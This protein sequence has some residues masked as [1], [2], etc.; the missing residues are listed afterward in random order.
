MHDVAKPEIASVKPTRKIVI[1]AA[2]AVVGLFLILAGI[3]ALQIVK[4]VSSKPPMPVETVTSAQEKEEDWAPVLSSVGSVSAVQG[5]IVSVELGGT[6]SEVGFE[7]G[8]VAKKGDVLL[9]LD[10]S[11]EQAQLRTA[12]ADLELARADLER[13]RGL[14]ALNPNVDPLTR[15]VQVQATLENP[16][17]VLRPG[18]FA[19]VDVVLPE[20]H[21]ALVI[22]GSAISYAPYG[23]SVFV[24]EKKKDPK[25]GKESQTIRQ[26]FVRVGEA[27]GDFVSI[28][29]G[30][31]AGETVVGTGV[32]KLR[33]GMAVTIN[34]DL[35]PKPQ[36]NPTP[37]DS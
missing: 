25:S 21:K 1:K 27:R 16:D 22:P 17:H 14:T 8:G 7:S 34:N 32:F 35:A 2:L 18:M 11:S 23:D 12:E 5:A 36:V 13:S 15:N 28:N 30:L 26:Q 6:V 24:I 31:E 3:K 20:K 29:N 10:T 4:M 37:V 19:K 9:R 33:N